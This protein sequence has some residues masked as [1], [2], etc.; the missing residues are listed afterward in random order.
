MWALNEMIS[1]GLYS[2]D[3]FELLAFEPAFYGIASQINNQI[4]TLL[5]YIIDTPVFNYHRMII[6]MSSAVPNFLIN[7][8]WAIDNLQKKDFIISSTF[9]KFENQTMD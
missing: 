4:T 9:K 5:Q 3:D 1:K 6:I 8:N 7:H 2:L